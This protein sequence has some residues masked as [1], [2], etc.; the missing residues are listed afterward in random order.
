[1]R[2]ILL[3]LAIGL[4][5]T[6]AAV[7]QASFDRST[8]AQSIIQYCMTSPMGQG[9]DSPEVACGCAAGLLSG[10]SS[11]RQFHVIGRLLPFMANPDGLEAEGERL[12]SEGYSEE[13]LLAVAQI[14]EE[15]IPVNDATCWSLRR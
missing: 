14:I 9:L 13:E 7:A 3:A 15:A 8:I 1:M 5:P 2:L 4:A 6:G 12:A 10:R 11:D